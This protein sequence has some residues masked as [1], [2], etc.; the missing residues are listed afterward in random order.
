MELNMRDRKEGKER[1]KKKRKQN[2]KGKVKNLEWGYRL[3]P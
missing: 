2:R 3:Y 1:N